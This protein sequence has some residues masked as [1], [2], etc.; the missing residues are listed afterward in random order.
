MK[1]MQFRVLGSL[2][3]LVMF[4]ANITALA[5]S[6]NAK[7]DVAKSMT[8]SIT[9]LIPS[10]DNV[11]SL[12]TPDL[13]WKSI[14]IGESSLSFI[15]KV[16]GSKVTLGI[17][18]GKLLINNA[19]AIQLGPLQF[20]PTGIKALDSSADITIGNEGDTGYLSTARGIK[21]PDGSVQTTAT[22][23][24]V[25]PIGPAGRDGTKGDKGEKGDTG[26]S[27]GPQG[28]QGIQGAKGDKGDK[29]DPGPSGTTGFSEQ[30]VCVATRDLEMRL[31]TCLQ[32]GIAG[33]NMTILV[34]PVTN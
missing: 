31:G 24:I 19:S 9:N 12:G 26:M 21:F 15:D 6:K 5:W 13:R 33:T 34:K 2:L 4:G 18:D 29:G 17:G 7:D 1:A 20:T 25:G 32:L 30:P 11:Y 10:E 28:F 14:N 3:I 27:G 22:S 16:N 8:R 23:L